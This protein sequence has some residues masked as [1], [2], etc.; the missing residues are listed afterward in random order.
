MSQSYQLTLKLAISIIIGLFPALSI[1]VQGGGS[2]VLILLFLLGLVFAWPAWREISQREKQ[3]MWSLLGYALI[4]ALSYAFISEWSL[5]YQEI[6]RFAR[7]VAIIPIYLLLRRFK[8]ELLKP[9]LL[10]TAVAIV[11]LFYQSLTL[12]NVGDYGV[13]GVYYRIYFGDAVVLYTLWLA[14]GLFLLKHDRKVLI[15]GL[16]LI[17]MGL[18]ATV[19][20][21]CR[22]AW[23]FIPLLVPVLLFLFRQHV[24]RSLLSK[25]AIALA[26][27]TLALVIW[28]PPSLEKGME[29]GVTSLESFAEKPD[30]DSSLA[31]RIK[32]WHDSLIMAERHPIFG[33][34]VGGFEKAR[35]AMIDKGETYHGKPYGHAHNIFLH[36][37]ATTGL[38][39][40]IG[41]I[42]A[43]FVM[44]WRVLYQQWRA[45][46]SDPWLRFS[47]L[48]G[49]LSLVA[50]AHFGLTEAWITRNPFINFYVLSIV[51][52]IAA[53]QNRNS[54]ADRVVEKTSRH[55]V[56]ADTI[57]QHHHNNQV[58]QQ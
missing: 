50:F 52:F 19:V 46:P 15:V 2:A 54:S 53:T 37:L 6:E 45:N 5:A 10:G 58:R 32:L 1:A 42:I 28:T 21:I 55:S 30:A 35:Q 44:P 16:V 8:P 17:V 34:G 18:Y 56:S 31:S 36:A 26:L 4:I 41:L 43:L 40:M 38:L 13:S 14:L 20:S 48:G 3:W 11:I 51:M 29:S 49:L 33:V 39:G 12:Y 7:L 47:L 25:L 9:V 24:T 57:A 22:N 27:L 23:L